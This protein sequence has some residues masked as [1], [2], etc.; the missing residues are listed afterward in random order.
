MT[1][2]ENIVKYGRTSKYLE[3]AD[4]CVEA[5]DKIT[6]DEE[7]VIFKYCHAMLLLH[8]KS[9][10]NLEKG[11]KEL[12]DLYNREC[13]ES[14]QFVGF[15]IIDLKSKFPAIYYGLGKLSTFTNLLYF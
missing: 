11:F 7:Y 10:S 14:G 12:N 3:A 4:I 5:L 15:L 1:Y 8:S 13:W 6:S 9:L 2:L